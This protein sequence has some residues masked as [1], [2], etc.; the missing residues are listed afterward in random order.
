[1]NKKEKTIRILQCVS[2]MNRAG[3]ETMLMNFYR[4]IDR[5]EVQFDFLCNKSKPGDYDDEIR[6]LGGN[7]YVFPGLNSLKWFEYQKYMKN[8]LKNHPEYKIIHCQNEATGF[9]ALYAERKAGIPV[10]ICA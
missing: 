3:I 5:N 1:M 7:I 8:L 2:N 9:P 10:R 4:N 6:K